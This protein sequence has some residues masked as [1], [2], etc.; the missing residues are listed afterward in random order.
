MS[1]VTGCEFNSNRIIPKGVKGERL[2]VTVNHVPSSIEP[3]QIL[4]VKFPRLNQNDV[5]V[6]NTTR[7][8]F[9]LELTS[10]NDKRTV[11]HNL[12]RNL[13]SKMT[14]KLNNLE[15]QSIHDY[16]VVKGYMDLWKRYKVNKIIDGFITNDGQTGEI[17]K[18][19]LSCSDK[20][21]T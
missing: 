21:M 20:N 8:L 10:N 16:D 7:I 3:G 9:D 4:T 14:V 1:C 11:V 12:S 17:M 5:V 6:P 13:V 19:R 15:V 18:H 2:I